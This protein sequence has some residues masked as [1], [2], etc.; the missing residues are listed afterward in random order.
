M[1]E[2]ERDRLRPLGRRIASLVSDYLSKRGRR[3]RLLEEA[4]EL[5]QEYGR[6]LNEEGLSLKDGLE[7]FTFFRKGLDDAVVELVRRNSFEVEELAEVWEGL[8]GLGDQILL[9]LGDSY[10]DVRAAAAARATS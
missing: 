9:G 3:Q 5:G 8:A 7:A 6:E 2:D 4:R 1:E 10:E